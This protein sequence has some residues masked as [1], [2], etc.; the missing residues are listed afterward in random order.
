MTID[1]TLKNGSH[2]SPEAG[3]CAMEWVAYLAGE[4]HTD[5][6]VCVDAPLRSFGISL[7]DDW[8]DERRQKLRPYLVRC[9]GTAGDGRTEE[10]GWLAV[11]WLIRTFTPA[12]LDLQPE[13]KPHAEKLR[14]LSPVM[15][16]EALDEA[17]IVLGESKE[18]AYAAA[19]AAW[20]AA[21]AAAGDAA[22]A[23]ARA[24]ARAAAGDAARAAAGDAAWAAAGDAAWAAAGAAAGDAAWAA[25]GAA[26]G[27]A[28]WA[29][30][31]D[32]AWDALKPTVE[33]LQDSAL[34][35][36]DRMIGQGEV[37]SLPAEK[38]ADYDRLLETAS[39]TTGR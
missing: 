18:A 31:G 1:Y 17:M 23:A 9:I 33:Q 14:R 8:D 2:D 19:D 15:A 28:A 11:D 27:D 7:N 37:L 38:Q 12:F 4:K 25:A 35:L 26:A 29:A 3:L 10:R 5:Q 22:W 34:D 32:A 16:H 20:A 30:A 24:A 6:P 39:A 36:F 21:G 13:L